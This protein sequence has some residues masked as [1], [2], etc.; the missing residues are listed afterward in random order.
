MVYEVLDNLDITALVLDRVDIDTLVSAVDVEAIVD[1]VDIA[2]IVDAIEHKRC[3]VQVVEHLVHH[4]RNDSRDDLVQV[5]TGGC[6]RRAARSARAST[7][8][9]DVGVASGWAGA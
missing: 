4:G 7:M 1:R 3:D 9:L 8:R 2:A 5:G 6:P